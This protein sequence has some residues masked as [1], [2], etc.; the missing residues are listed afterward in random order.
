[1]RD[2]RDA[3]LNGA[4]APAQSREIARLTQ[5]KIFRVD[6]ANRILAR[7]HPT[8]PDD[9]SA[10]DLAATLAAKTGCEVEIWDE[11][12]FVARVNRDGKASTQ[13][14]SPDRLANPTVGS[15]GWV[16]EKR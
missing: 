3:Q 13:R 15:F 9:L 8:L 11:Q 7:H 4:R 6:D 16:S 10:L 12:R 1:L 2:L 5:Y 14:T